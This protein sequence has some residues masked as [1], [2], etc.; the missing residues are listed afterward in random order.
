MEFYPF[1][2]E[3]VDKLER[4]P[5]ALIGS[6]MGT[7]KT[8]EAIE[9][10]QR[11]W[12]SKKQLPTLVVAPLNTH[13]SWEEKYGWQAPN[14]DVVRINRKNRDKFADDI[15]RKRG[16]V[17]VMHYDAL[18]LM[19]ELQKIA[20]GTIIGDEIHRIANRKSQVTRAMY[21]LHGDHRLGLSGTASGDRPDQ[22]WS[23]L[24]WLYPRY[25]TSY[26]KFRRAYCIEEKPWTMVDGV[27]KQA[28]YS[29]IVGVQNISHLMDH[30]APWYVRHLKR[31][32]CC[33][34]HPEGVMPWLPE[35]TYDTIW[36]DLM[37]KQRRMYEQMR[38]N[39]VAWVNEHE[40]TPLSAAIVVS[41]LAR[42]SQIALATPEIV[43]K[44][45]VWRNYKNQETGE[46]EKKRVEVD[47]V[48]LTEPSTKLDAVQEYIQDHSEHQFVIATSS[49]QAANLAAEKFARK[50]ITSFV[51]SGDTKEKDRDGMVKRFA[52]GD[53]QLFISVIEAG[54]EG[55]D[56]LQEA[57][58]KMIFLDR[59]WRTIK[60]MQQ[61]DRLHRDGQKN[62]VQIIDVVAHDTVDL[63]RKQ[64]LQTKWEWIKELLG[65]S[66]GVQQREMAS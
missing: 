22:M 29:Q 54:A 55:I 51:L 21:K 53:T 44:K 63:G 15:R 47:D 18:R 59:S 28:D 13:D 1:Q 4:Q 65:D 46:T 20:Y 35:K 26:W 14:I 8:H 41:Q 9:L 31:D 64:R 56:G 6:E 39:M 12:N 49:K 48:R 45:W 19:P 7:G 62:T 34:H 38:Q 50:G 37:P 23:I 33:K 36:V 10:D 27:A 3:D 42:L 5:A 40:D 32:Q 66:Q 11:W 30:M 16:D 60:N 61:E 52:N 57:T 58:D 2:Q 24:H 25:Y 17:F 43:G